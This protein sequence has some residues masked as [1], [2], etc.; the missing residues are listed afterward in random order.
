VPGCVLRVRYK[1]D[2]EKMSQVDEDKL[3]QAA[4]LALSV[5]LHAEIVPSH[6][7]ARMPQLNESAVLTPMAA[8]DTYLTEVTEDPV[9]RERLLNRA[10]EI[11]Q[12]V[13]A[14]IAGDKEH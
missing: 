8:L 1:I 7:R 4:A 11:M 2:Q 3:R 5:K 6:L 10:K 13:S 12:K 9:K 14:Q